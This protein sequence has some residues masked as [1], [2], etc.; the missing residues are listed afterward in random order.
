[1]SQRNHTPLTFSEKIFSMT[2]NFKVKFY[3]PI[4][5]LCK[6]C[7]STPLYLMLSLTFTKLYYIKHNHILNYYISLKSEKNCDI[8]ATVCLISTKFGM[9][10]QN[11]SLK[12][13]AVKN[14]NF[15]NLRWRTAAI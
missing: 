15:K 7:K 8:A 9:M 6:N 5:Y 2:E 12:C 3:M 10:T 14:L 4:L 1:M 13:T 11:V